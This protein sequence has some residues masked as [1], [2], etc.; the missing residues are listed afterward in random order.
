MHKHSLFGIPWLGLMPVTQGWSGAG[1]QQG[2]AGTPAS[3]TVQLP[4]PSPTQAPHIINTGTTSRSWYLTNFWQDAAGRA[5]LA[6]NE[7]HADGTWAVHNA[8]FE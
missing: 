5:V 3:V 6:W 2:P 8:R 1:S 7:Q 4:T